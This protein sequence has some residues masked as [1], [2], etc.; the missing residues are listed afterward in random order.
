M[1]GLSRALLIKSVLSLLSSIRTR[2][3]SISRTTLPG[4]PY[5]ENDQQFTENS[6]SLEA[7]KR[8]STLLDT[9]DHPEWHR[10]STMP[11]CFPQ[12]PS[13]TKAP[14]QNCVT[15]LCTIVLIIAPYMLCL[16]LFRPIDSTHAT[17]ISAVRA[18]MPKPSAHKHHARK[19]RQGSYS[20]GFCRYSGTSPFVSGLPFRASFSPS[21]PLGT[22]MSS[23]SARYF[24]ASRAAMQP[25]P[26]VT[27]VS[28]CCSVV[29]RDRG[30]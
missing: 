13:Q 10:H 7:F 8:C 21:I 20:S 29:C 22:S 26:T 19:S 15:H 12:K 27:R 14:G 4:A 16:I 23:C 2:S 30:T 28:V 9:Q 17:I 5:C 25:E 18:S 6:C 11:P 3:A 1:S 24:S